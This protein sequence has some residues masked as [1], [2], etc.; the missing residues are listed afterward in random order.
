M[1]SAL[2]FVWDKPTP[3]PGYTGFLEF[4]SG[5]AMGD[6]IQKASGERFAIKY[7]NNVREENKLMALTMTQL[8]AGEFT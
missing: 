6:I 4:R 7:I 3:F 1:G 2:S 5:I 8:K